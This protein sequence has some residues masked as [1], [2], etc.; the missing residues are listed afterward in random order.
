MGS[1]K[2]FCTLPNYSKQC[3]EGKKMLED[4][5]FEVIENT[6]GRPLSQQEVWDYCTNEE[7]VAVVAGVDIWDE[8]SYQ[9][10]T[11]LKVIA[12]FGVG[13]DN[14]DLQKGKEYGIKICNAKAGNAVSVAEFAVT[15]MLSC[16][17]KLCFFNESVRKGEWDRTLGF[18][19][20]GKKVGLVGFGD[21]SRKVAKMLSGFGVEIMASDMYP[22]LEE[23]K[24]LNVKITSFE[25]I[26]EN[27]D[28]ISIHVPSTPETKYLFNKK[29]FDKMKSN[30][31]LIN[32]AR[33]PI[34]EQS[35]LYEALKEGKIAGA[36]LD[37]YEIEP[38]QSNNPL[39]ELKNIVVTPHTAAETHETYH[40]VGIMTAQAVI[41]VLEG[42][43][44]KNLLNA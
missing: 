36:G 19:L 44:P 13:V 28:I 1:K 39:F 33:G 26:L 8:A 34:V 31:V 16:Y 12:R 41:D 14:L 30:A 22:N 20:E 17:K 24:K 35:A 11:N 2:V 9:K 25:N 4:N 42:K 3:A 18:N 43:V 15:F 10:F 6:L 38:T 29:S 40:N 37:V 23:A 5:G 32:T 7:V 27:C 21:I